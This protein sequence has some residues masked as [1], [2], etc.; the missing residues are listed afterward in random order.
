MKISELEKV[1]GISRHTLRFY[2]REGLLFGVSRS[3]NN[4]RVYSEEAVDQVKTVCHLKDMGFTLSEIRDLLIAIRAD[5]IDCE[6][7]AR[8]VADKKEQLERKISE[9][10]GIRSLLDS[11]QARLEKSAEAQ[12]AKKGS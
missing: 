5:S 7:A 8:F 3:E 4:Y 1:T 12:R 6:T 9:L 11:E 10:Q 2:E